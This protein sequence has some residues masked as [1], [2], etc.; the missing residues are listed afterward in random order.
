[1]VPK[2]WGEF[3]MPCKLSNY[4]ILTTAYT[5]S[6]QFCIATSAC[7]TVHVAGVCI[8]VCFCVCISVC[9][10]VCISVCFCVCISRCELQCVFFVYIFKYVCIS[11][12]VFCVCILRCVLQCV[13]VWVFQCVFCVYIFVFQ[14]VYFKV[15]APDQFY[16]VH[17]YK[18]IISVFMRV[19][20]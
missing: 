19:C 1:M 18:Y 5:F 9:F 11:V 12:C 2:S 8:S 17:V 15:C 7:L 6:P 20:V 14:C 4:R 16:Y 13:H 3:C 10:C